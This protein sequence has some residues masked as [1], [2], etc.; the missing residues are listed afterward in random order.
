MKRNP[1]F[2]FHIRS[3]VFLLLVLLLLTAC[4]DTAERKQKYFDRGMDLYEQGN[5]TKARLEF[6]NVLQIDPKDADAHFMFGQ[7]EE[8]EENW[9]KAYAL[10]FRAVELNPKHVDAQVHL[11]TIYAMA[12]EIDKALAAAEVAL[13]IKP[14]HSSAL[15]LRGFAM[16]RSG[17]SDSAI[18]EVLAAI[19]SEPGNVEAASLL[20]ELYA[21]QGDLDRAIKIAKDSLEKNRERVASYL[22]LARLYAQTDK[23]ERVVEVL[24]DL[25]RIKPD[26][27]QNRLHLVAYYKDKGK[28]QEAENV[29]RRAVKDLPD[30]MDAKLGLISFLKSSGKLESAELLLH[31]YAAASSDNY[32]FKLELARYY[33]GAKRKPEA[34]KVLADVIDLA[35]LTPDGLKARTIKASFLVK[36]GLTVEA[37]ELI[38]EVFE[39]DPKNKDALLV[40]AGIALVSS[41]PDKGIA[42]LRTLLRE[43]PGYVKAHRLKARAHL[44]KGEVELARQS[45]ENA[46]KIQPQ[47]SAANFELVQLLIG[48]GEFDDAVVV[49]QKMR[50][51]VP[52][53]LAVL[54]GLAM[55]YDKLKSWDELSSIAKVIQSEHKDSPL[56][57]YY[58]GVS[59]QERGE[60]PQSIAELTKALERQPG[61]IE[62]L[63]ALAKSYFAM[64]QPDEALQRIEKVVAS[65]P[66]NYRA[67]NL[68][69][70]VYL[71]QK[72]LR[73][74]ERAFNRALAINAEWSVPYRNL[75]KIK[76]LEDSQSEAIALLELGFDKTLD[77]LLGIELAST[78]D[79]L[80]QADESI[81]VYQRILDK[82]PKHL[83][84]A[85][86][87]VMILL[88]GEPDQRRLDQAMSLVD[89]FATS[90]N[91]I[92]LDTLGWVHLKRGETDEA[93]SV[94]RRAARMNSGLPE[95]DYHL[96]L[97]LYQKGELEAAKNHLNVALSAE[98]VFEG[99]ED[100]KVLM[101]K[102]P[103]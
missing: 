79:K 72:R 64:K 24:T 31:E 35:G 30:S 36:D 42:D 57:Y 28:L 94:F 91:P 23:D 18:D 82:Y 13:Q 103:D 4:S 37:G 21:D 71:S 6:K 70:E 26:E 11:G 5:F 75:I 63:V 54:R 98:R 67:F 8:K 40:R 43:D 47:E 1:V 7:L 48:T 25:I 93:I 33:I 34:L 46:V 12:G 20:S 74:A 17:K 22:L 66:D 83:L 27:L 60:V 80:G 92:V 100:A 99:M 15:V 51:F 76:L 53:D 45:L 32:A 9:R 39:V 84:A 38:D 10:Y 73:E 88:R 62:V 49:L 44:K 50:R 41:D 89:G 29:F 68:M 59:L 81:Q 2:H 86:N 87:L 16:A 97:A 96:A 55:L 102:L 52:K 58:Q 3:F 65:N 14:T 90:E 61:S 19:E 56:G 78:K 69:G 85:N 95:I 77:P 101:K